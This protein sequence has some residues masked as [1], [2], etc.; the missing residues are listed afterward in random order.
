MMLVWQI[1][2]I[3]T[4]IERACVGKLGFNPK[5]RQVVCLSGDLVRYH[6]NPLPS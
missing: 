3:I 4:M 2:L 5:P 6:L 1:K